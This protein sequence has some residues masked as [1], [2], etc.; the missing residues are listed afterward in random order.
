MPSS[1]G[2][3]FRGGLELV[4]E[5][6]KRHRQLP[7]LLTAETLDE[8][9]R[10]AAKKW[11]IGGVVLKPALSKLDAAEYREDLKR[12]AQA[13]SERV[14]EIAH[15]GGASD[16][17]SLSDSE[18]DAR[19]VL[20]MLQSVS[21]QLVRADGAGNLSS[22]ILHVASRFF[23]RAILFSIKANRARGMAGFGLA[24]TREGSMEL[25]QKFVFDLHQTPAFAEL[26]HGKSAR[27]MRSGDETLDVPSIRHALRKP[28]CCPS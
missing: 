1:S 22:S 12:F 16:R 8:D 26:V 5:I 25:A 19:G 6:R 17:K 13:L 2:E 20:E 9:D 21:E 10:A 7:I 28:F 4:R 14:S 23:E 11:D 18:I 24:G 27:R 15:G 3:D